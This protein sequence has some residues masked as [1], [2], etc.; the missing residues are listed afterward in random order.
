MDESALQDFKSLAVCGLVGKYELYSH[1]VTMLSQALAGQNV[2][3]TAGTGSG[4]TESFL[5]PL[6]AYLAKE[7]RNWQAP[8]SEHPRLNDWWK[9]EDWQKNVS[10]KRNILSVLIEFHKE[11]MKPVM[12]R[13]EL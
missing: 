5:L 10:Q 6:F 1:Q 12:L 9:N 7:S 4:K 3:V 2:V 8:N 11:Y 13:Y